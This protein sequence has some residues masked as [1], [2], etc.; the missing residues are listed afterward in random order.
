MKTEKEDGPRI[1]R[2]KKTIEAMV[3]LYCKDKHHTQEELCPDCKEFLEYALNRLDN[4]PFQEDKPTCANCLIHCYS[5]Q[6]RKE[7]KKI[8]KYSG[9]KLLW[10]HP[11]LA[12][13]HLLD[14]LK[15][16]P[17]LNKQS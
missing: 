14:G 11:I 9:P 15:E 1:K 4:C 16:P 7:A 13:K 17:K 2:E 10:H 5:Q 8:M 6:K 12:I 3:H